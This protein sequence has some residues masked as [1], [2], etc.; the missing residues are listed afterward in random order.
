[1]KT[2]FQIFPS[3]LHS[4]VSLLTDTFEFEQSG[5][6]FLYFLFVAGIFVALIYPVLLL[7]IGIETSSVSSVFDVWSS[8]LT[9]MKKSKKRK[10]KKPPPKN[11]LSRLRHPAAYFLNS[12]GESTP[13]DGESDEFEYMLRDNSDSDGDGPKQSRIHQRMLNMSSSSHRS[14]SNFP[15]V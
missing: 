2:R 1:M 12:G 11:L 4:P 3:L 5:W 9:R 13:P 7:P 8:L 14:S 6:P 10:H 15:L